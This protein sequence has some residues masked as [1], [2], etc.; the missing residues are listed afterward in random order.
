MIVKIKRSWWR[1]AVSDVCS[2][3]SW[4]ELLCARPPELNLFPGGREVP[5]PES[6]MCQVINWEISGPAGWRDGPASVSTPVCSKTAA[7]SSHSLCLLSLQNTVS[8]S[9]NS[10]GFSRI[11][12]PAR[13]VV[14]LYFVVCE[15]QCLCC[16]TST[17]LRKPVALVQLFPR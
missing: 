15:H 5:V 3:R 2:S 4:N 7:S 10:L 6:W 17:R 1:S 9:Q 12:L 16:F 13:F 8:F 11:L 14:W